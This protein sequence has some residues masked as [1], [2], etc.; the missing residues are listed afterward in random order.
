GFARVHV[1]KGKG[2]IVGAT[3]VASHA[4]DMIGIFSM[5]MNHQ[6]GLGSIANVIHPYPTQGEAVRKLGDLYNRTKLTPFVK[7][8]FNKWLSW[9]R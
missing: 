9:S 8:L 5:A 6:I 3:I 4:G 7:R 1:V 2:K